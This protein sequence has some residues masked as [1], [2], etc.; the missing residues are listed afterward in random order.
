MLLV[1]QLLNENNLLKRPS[2]RETIDHTDIIHEFP[3]LSEEEIGD[4]T[5]G[6]KLSPKVF[7][8]KSI[9]ISGVYQL[10]RARSY[11]EEKTGTSN[12]TETVDYTILRCRLFPDIIRV[13]TQSAHRERTTYNPTI[14]F[15]KDEILGWW[16][17][18][19]IGNRF[20]GCC[21]HIT[22]AIWFLSYQRWQSNESRRASPDMMNFVSDA[23]PISDFYDS[24]DDDDSSTHHYSI[25]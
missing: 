5:L 18:C 4:I 6:T 7:L 16:C 2:A 14:R 20:L 17:D 12:L 8:L 10:K 9:S 11:A 3:I 19:S 25:R 13:P 23:I 15:S 24:S 22:S 1:F 21:S